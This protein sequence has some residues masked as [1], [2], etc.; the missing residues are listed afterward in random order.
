[1]IDKP[2]TRMDKNPPSSSFQLRTAFGWYVKF[3]SR[4]SM[5]RKQLVMFYIMHTRYVKLLVRNPLS[6]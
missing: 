5:S 4:C 3:Q 6:R 1:M 2:G